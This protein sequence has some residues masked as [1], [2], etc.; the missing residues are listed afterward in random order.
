MA[1]MAN[2]MAEAMRKPITVIVDISNDGKVCRR[3]RRGIIEV[4][5]SESIGVRETHTDTRIQQ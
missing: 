1:D 4:R 5:C 2:D 3:R